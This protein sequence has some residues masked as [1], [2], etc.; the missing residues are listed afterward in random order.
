MA[1]PGL[2]LKL[3]CPDQAGI[4][5]KIANY[6]ASHR[7]NLVEFN[8]FS[9]SL[10]GKFLLVSKSKPTTSMFKLRIS[11]TASARSGAR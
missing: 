8:Q 3:S 10:E 1:R 5:A 4:V 9:D 2:I 6:V 11:S 7:G